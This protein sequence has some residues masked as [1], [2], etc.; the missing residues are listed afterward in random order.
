M[1]PYFTNQDLTLLICGSLL[2]ITSVIVFHFKKRKA[3]LLLL[4]A[5]TFLFGCFVAL[6]NNY[7]STWDE[8]FHAVVAKNMMHHPFKPMFYSNPVLGYDYK[9][10]T[11]N[12]IWLHKQP[13]FLWQM[14]ATMAVFGVNIFGL[15]LPSIL[16]HAVL[17]VFIYRIGKITVNEKV[18][19]Y[20]ALLFAVAHY[21]LEMVS[22][23]YASDHNDVAFLF[24]FMASLW[25][26]FEYWNSGNRKWLLLIGVFAGCAFLV[27]WTTGLL[28]F[29][30]WGITI[31]INNEKRIKIRSYLDWLLSFA[32]ALI[33][34]L[35][36]QL[37]ILFAFPA[38]AK[39]EF[40]MN[41]KHLTHCIEEH[42]GNFWFHIEN[43]SILYGSAVLI[44][45]FILLS[46]I[47]Y[48]IKIKSKDFKV[49]IMGIVLITY[50]VFSIAQTKMISYTAIAMPVS[51]LSVAA[52]IDK[53]LGFI[54][55]FLKQKILQFI[56]STCVLIFIS[57]SFLDLNGVYH[58]HTYGKYDENWLFKYKTIEKNIIEQ[59]RNTL[60]KPNYV[61]FNT[62]YQGYGHAGY[63]FYTDFTAYSY[64]PDKDQISL[65]KNKGHR[66]AILDFGDLPDYIISDTGITKIVTNEQKIK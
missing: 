52:F 38:E 63:L 41:S 3:A 10:W 19:F 29:A 4:M 15:R 14:A 48:I 44:P 5:G 22:G 42:C 35:P 21:P 32:A 65:L 6:I 66:I 59:V 60:T 34:L 61:V 17:C 56:I 45:Y 11:S 54:F 31:L 24:Y 23:I 1:Y 18:G 46:L 33:V 28:V 25:A 62:S 37:Y 27:K 8:Q 64:I 20:G 47:V 26:W 51:F 43:M 50:L 40:L 57:Y 13:L 36:W 12:H 30:I 49:A 9:D 7:L 58:N 53:V 39:F 2:L 55:R 16:Q